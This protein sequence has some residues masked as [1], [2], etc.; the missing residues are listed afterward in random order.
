MQDSTDRIKQL[1]A[2]GVRDKVYPGAVWA[3][4]NAV[5]MQ[6]AGTAGVLDPTEPDIPM[7]PDTVFDVASLT[8][9]LAVWSTIGTLWE[10]GALP[11][12]DPLG[13]FWPE[14]TG[15]PLGQASA[16]QLLTHTAGVPLRAQLK[17]LYGTVPA[18]IRAGVLHEALH[19]PPGEAVE[20]T[21]RAALILGYL[22][23][24]LS[25]Q[26]LDQL[27][28]TRIWQPLG[29]TETRFGPLPP[30]LT[31]RCAPTELDE[32]TGRHLK[33]IAHDF[34]ARL[35]GGVCGIAGAFSTLDDLT[36]FLKYMLDPT[37]AAVAPGFGPNWV[38]E[39]L[40]VQTG[41]LEPVR[42]L[43]WH[44]AP[45]TAP[46]NRTY[47]HYGFT[48]TG[49]WISPKRGTWAVLLTNKLYYTRDREPLTRIRNAFG[50]L[51][52]G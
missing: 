15:H 30:E 21:D 35:L 42:G 26:G 41:T 18:T 37:T 52:F 8:K 10:D 11:L 7:R 40:S 24:R 13:A 25:G 9:I 28:P 49:M 14:V 47:V 2:D 50:A 46:T 27:A 3:I 16:R 44:P 17:N 1:V 33:G 29:M 4:G 32:D 38:E 34:S 19:R 20:Y 43:F 36:R 48:G 12:D 39:S 51:T 6:A 5:G 31:V 23:E 45:G 22:A